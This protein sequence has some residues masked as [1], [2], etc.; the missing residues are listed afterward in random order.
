MVALKRNRKAVEGV[1]YNTV[2]AL[3]FDCCLAQTR[4]GKRLL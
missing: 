3:F 2:F 4:V 1:L